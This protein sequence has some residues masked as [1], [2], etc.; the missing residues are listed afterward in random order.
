MR[1]TKYLLRQYAHF[2][3]TLLIQEKLQSECSTVFGSKNWFGLP[4]LQPNWEQ[5]YHYSQD[6]WYCPSFKGMWNL[7]KMS[8]FTNTLK[9]WYF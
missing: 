8:Y 2:C 3:I 1:R 5:W 7:K 9:V 4:S 6:P